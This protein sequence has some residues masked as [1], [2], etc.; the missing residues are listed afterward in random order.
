M[1]ASQQPPRQPPLRLLISESGEELWAEVT[2]K[3]VVMLKDGRR[4]LATH[5]HITKNYG[6]TND[7]PRISLY[8]G[9]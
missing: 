9:D 2:G 3:T 1:A 7:S 5:S 8:G 6:G 4:V